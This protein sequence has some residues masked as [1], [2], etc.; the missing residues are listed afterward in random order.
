MH[1]VKAVIFDMDGTLLDSR[2]MIYR[3][4][5]EVLSAHNVTIT[6]D[7]ISKVVGKPIKAMYEILAPELDSDT[8]EQA[9]L[10]HHKDHLHLSRL[11]AN[12]VS[13]L[14]K[15]RARDIRLGIFTGFNQLAY[16]RLA[17]FH[18][19]D[20]FDSI[21][22]STRYTAHKPDPEGLYVAMNDLGITDPKEVIFVGDAIMDIEAGKAAGVLQTIGITHGFNDRDVL[23]KAGADVVIDELLQLLPVIDRYEEK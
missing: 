19:I 22:D 18:I 5:E 20:L 16:D 9:H 1:K 2:E 17:T 15:I 21:V 8:L 12:T 7:E 23:Q 4:M 3:A 14:Q 10:N 6:R 11:Y 13:V